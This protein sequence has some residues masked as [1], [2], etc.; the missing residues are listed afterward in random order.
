MQAKIGL[1]MRGIHEQALR[2]GSISAAYA[3]VESTG[4]HDA[5]CRSFG[6]VAD[7][8]LATPLDPGAVPGFDS[9]RPDVL[10]TKLC[11]QL[12]AISALTDPGLSPEDQDARLATIQELR[13]NVGTDLGREIAARAQTTVCQVMESLRLAL[14]RAFGSSPAAARD[15]V[16]NVKAAL[17]QMRLPDINDK[18]LARWLSLKKKA[19]KFRQ[20]RAVI[21]QT[22][23]KAVQELIAGEVRNLYEQCLRSLAVTHILAAWLDE[24][25][26]IVRFLD[27]LAKRT[28]E[29]LTALA[30]VRKALD[31]E[32]STVAKD[33]HVSRASVVMPL[34]GPTEDQIVAGMIGHLHAGDEGGLSKIL[35]D[36][37]A[38]ALRELCPHVCAWIAPDESLPELIRNIPPEDQAHSFLNVVV[39]AMGP[40][41]S[42]YETLERAGIE[43][44]VEFLHSHSAPTVDLSG[45]DMPQLSVSP[46]DI[47]IA[48][49]PKPLTAKDCKLHDEV[50]A[51]FL[52]LD[53]NCAFADAPATDRT[54][55]A[56]RLIVGWPIGIEGQNANLLNHYQE[57]AKG[58]HRPH[59]FGILP[60]SPHGQALDQYQAVQSLTQ[61]A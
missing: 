55:T 54:I 7:R 12:S 53:P 1:S 29:V 49:L 45:R 34:A 20:C 35:L 17:E 46:Q 4:V 19:D 28:N 38:A 9:L 41:Q 51:A 23:M 26:K 50:R 39:Q 37:S 6:H 58:G 57:A 42:L 27:D 25:V 11:S 60:D 16:Q 43:S 36:R 40:G 14:T 8:F 31:Q 5:A 33:Q 2:R 21:P 59:L 44:C 24:K 52:K 22:S 48:T 13:G 30:A 32:R 3:Q 15:A 10:V 47:C 18:P 61:L 56:V